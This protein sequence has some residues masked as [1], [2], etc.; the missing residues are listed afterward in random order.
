MRVCRKQ[1]NF[2]NAPFHS[3]RAR[4]SSHH[5]IRFRIWSHTL[6]PHIRTQTLLL[7]GCFV[8]FD[9]ILYTITSLKDINNCGPH[10]LAFNNWIFCSQERL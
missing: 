4:F 7:V 3:C 2:E 9:R 6:C 1:T 10:D 5:H 8:S